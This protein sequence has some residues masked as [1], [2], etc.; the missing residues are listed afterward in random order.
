MPTVV[1]AAG[2][3]TQPVRYVHRE[4]SRHALLYVNSIT[5]SLIASAPADV[6]LNIRHCSS[7]ASNGGDLAGET[8][9]Y[10][11]TKFI[12]MSREIDKRI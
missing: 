2:R 3:Q 1:C 7:S 10:I 11:D 8:V 5:S 6:L 9:K 12:Q 4:R